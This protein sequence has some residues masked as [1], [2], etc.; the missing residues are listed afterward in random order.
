MMQKKGHAVI[1]FALLLA[2]M[3]AFSAQAADIRSLGSA[4]GHPCAAGELL[5]K[6][7]EG[8][9]D[10]AAYAVHR[11]LKVAEWRRGYNDICQIVSFEPGREGELAEAYNRRHEVMYAEPNY[12]ATACSEPNDQYYR[13]QWSFPLINLP[14]AW[15]ISTGEGVVVAVVDTGINPFGRDGFGSLAGNRLLWGYNAITGTR[16]GIDFNHHGTHVA[17]T[18]GQE[19]NNRIGVAGIAYNAKLLPVKA[20]AFHGGGFYYSIINGIRWATDNDANV[21]N[22]SL[23]AGSDSRLLE[24]AVDYAYEKG[25]TVVAAAGN[26]GADN[27]LYPAA[28]SHCI[29]VGAIQYDK[30]FAPYSNYGEKL[31][32]VAPGGNLEL[33][34][35]NDGYKDGIL[36]ETFQAFGIGW[37]Y[38]FSTGTSMATPHVAG[39]AALIKSIRPEYG[40]DDIRRVLQDTAQDLGEPGRDERY[41]YGLVDAYAAVSHAAGR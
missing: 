35:N 40:P 3:P 37:G 29:A 1:F 9:S 20:L 18:I 36:Q 8:V 33:D 25:V 16:G 12:Y 21:I 34:Q 22:L 31:D 6:F 19:T 17:G 30:R 5:I 26:D 39:V 13:L 23:G 14:A 38:W 7:R 41:G 27:I 11:D 10:R 2:G 24:E 15:D 28:F 4:N 32:L